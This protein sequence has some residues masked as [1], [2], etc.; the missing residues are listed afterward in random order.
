MGAIGPAFCSVVR[1]SSLT[2]VDS[3][4]TLV[5]FTAAPTIVDTHGMFSSPT[6]QLAVTVPGVYLLQACVLFAANATGNRYA[7]VNVG[8]ASVA[9]QNLAAVPGSVG[10]YLSLSVATVLNFGDVI[11]FY[12]RHTAGANLA[13]SAASFAPALSATW[14][15]S[16]P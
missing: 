11:S 1:P 12:V 4:D 6:T 8:A 2:V 7:W 10:T 16:H 9:R 5:D 15:R 14:M 3:T 13:A